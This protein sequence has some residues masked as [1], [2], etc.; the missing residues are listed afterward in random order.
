MFQQTQE[1]HIIKRNEPGEMLKNVKYVAKDQ[2]VWLF[3]SS[4]LG[5]SE[6]SGY[7]SKTMQL[8]MVESGF[9]LGTL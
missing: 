5:T 4:S 3:P 2:L 8:L 1:V 7:L 6:K 9:N